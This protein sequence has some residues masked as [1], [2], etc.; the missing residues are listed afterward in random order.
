MSC[1]RGQGYSTAEFAVQIGTSQAKKRL[2]EKMK[3]PR[4]ERKIAAESHDPLFD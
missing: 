4:G 1:R 3:K 2:V